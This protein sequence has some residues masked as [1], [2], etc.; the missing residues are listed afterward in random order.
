MKLSSQAAKKFFLAMTAA[1]V[2]LTIL[3]AIAYYV[4]YDAAIGYFSSA[5]ISSLLY[6]VP[7]PLIAAGMCVAYM[8]SPTPPRKKKGKQTPE[9]KARE[10]QAA[11]QR[12]KHVAALKKAGVAIPPDTLPYLSTAPAAS[13]PLAARAVDW[14]CAVAFFGAALFELLSAAPSYPSVVLAALAALAFALPLREHTDSPLIPLL[15]LA[16]IAWCVLAV[17]TEY[18]D[19]N[20][21][22]NGHTKNYAQFALCAVAL[23]LTAYARTASA[24]FNLYKQ[25]VCA[26]PAIVFGLS[27]SLA[28]FAALPGGLLPPHHLPYCA[29]VLTLSLH[30]LVAL[31][32]VISDQPIA[33]LIIP[34]AVLP[35][36]PQKGENRDQPSAEESEVSP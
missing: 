28:G 6:I 35:D 23:H 17:A 24:N 11:K 10:K 12:K 13:H 14:A 22:M 27:Y 33:T 31:S 15:Y 4:Q 19:W 1:T 7:V 20:F 30:A 5:W 21:P 26:V 18:F 25:N 2:L 32:P 9:Q 8:R 3:R 16:P 34:E 36:L 29:V